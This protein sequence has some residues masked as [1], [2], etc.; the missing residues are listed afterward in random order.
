MISAA[1]SWIASKHLAILASSL[2]EMIDTDNGSGF[3]E[4]PL[5]LLY[6]TWSELSWNGFY[7][8]DI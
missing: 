3:K 5:F 6:N 4:T 2:Y 8:E 1:I 7:Y